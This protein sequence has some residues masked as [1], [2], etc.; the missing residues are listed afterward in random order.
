ML[1]IGDLVAICMCGDEEAVI[2]DALRYLL[3][4]RS[5]LRIQLAIRRY[6]TEGRTL[7][8]AANLVSVSW[9]QMKKILI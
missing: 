3:R 9:M 5:D 6:E 1:K 7:V 4:A 2:Q 8:K